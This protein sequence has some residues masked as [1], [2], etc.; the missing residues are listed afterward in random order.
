[1]RMLSLVHAPAWRLA[2]AL[3]VGVIVL[4]T[5]MPQQQLPM[6]PNHF[7]KVEHFAAYGLLAVWFTGLVPRGQYW[8]VAVGLAV[9]GVVLEFL[10]QT[11]P[12]GRSGEFLDVVANVLGV[13]IGVA[14][15]LAW[16]GGWA[17]RLETWLRTPRA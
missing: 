9:L 11:M 3:L 8:R 16:S 4:V 15:A 13:A 17:L 12:L 10:Q 14:L 1:M 5:L 7:D 6:A 2:S